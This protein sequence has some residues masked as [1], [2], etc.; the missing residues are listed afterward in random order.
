[1]AT[2]L[3]WNI[4]RKPIEKIIANLAARHEVDVLML[5][6]CA[7]PS[8][9]LLEA[10][11]QD[12][13]FKYH[14]PEN[15]WHKLTIYTRFRREYLE[16]KKNYP[17]FTIRLLKLP[18]LPA[19]SLVVMHLVSKLGW[20]EKS[21]DSECIELANEVRKVEEE[22]RHSRTVLVGD[23][24][25]NPF[26]GG[27]ILANGLHAVMARS[28]ALRQSRRVQSNRYPFFYNPMWSLFGDATEG[29][30]GTYYFENAQH[31]IFFWNMF[32]QVLLRPD[33]LPFFRNEDLKI[34]TTDG[35]ISFLS[36]KGLPDAS[37]ASDHLPILFKLHL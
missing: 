27:V 16:T 2:F 28:I 6:E 18:G 17:R 35:T 4:N 7:I 34:L 26:Q 33:L 36:A 8:G 14:L 9:N 10:L 32:D 5:A 3:F 37:V 15:E 12:N 19:I 29:P 24:N 1:M 30:P 25:M 11:N 22:L 20:N 21:Q 31:D 23:L 13:E